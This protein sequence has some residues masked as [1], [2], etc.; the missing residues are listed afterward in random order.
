MIS[1]TF[2]K[3]LFKFSGFW[4]CNSTEN[5]KSNSDIHIFH[6]I[7]VSDC[8]GKDSEL[9]NYKKQ[10]SLISDLTL[11][12]DDLLANCKKQCRYEIRRGLKENYNID[13][14]LPEELKKNPEIINQFKSVYYSF[15][16]NKKI[17]NVYNEKAIHGYIDTGNLIVSRAEVGENGILWHAYI[18]DDRN[19]RLLY[20]ASNFHKLELDRALIGRANRVLHW[21][22]MIFL[23]ELG[24]EIMDWG[25]IGDP[26]NESGICKFKKSFGG[27]PHTSYTLIMANSLLGKV[28][29]TLMKFI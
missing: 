29:L 11:S 2:S 16:D 3:Y 17:A 23:K 5:V 26:S 22:D 8:K 4:F 14:F 12:L 19:S 20:S 24:L 15:V 13:F 7:P 10:Y 18:F 27:T 21:K 25:G 6:N 28:A 9:Y 1:V